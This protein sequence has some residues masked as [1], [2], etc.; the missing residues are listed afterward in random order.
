MLSG[1]GPGYMFIHLY[2]V[3]NETPRRLATS[4]VR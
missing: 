3:G 2:R 4:L 1:S